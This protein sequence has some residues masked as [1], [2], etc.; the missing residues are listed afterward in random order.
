M[1]IGLSSLLKKEFPNIKCLDRAI[2]VPSKNR[3]D[4]DWVSGFIEGDG[5]FFI[6]IRPKTNYVNAAISIGLN[7]R[8]KP[9]L[10]KIQEF[11]CGMGKVYTYDS[12]NI[13]E[14]KVVK[15]S[16]LTYIASHFKIYPLMGLKSYNFII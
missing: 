2:Y 6:Y 3:L 15:L 16:H 12:R 11:F 9:L 14:W 7:I 10:I 5:S 13:V 4:P 1:N 8:E